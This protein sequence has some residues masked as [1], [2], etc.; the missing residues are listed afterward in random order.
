M[1]D[2][3]NEKERI[4]ERT[5]KSFIWFT[6]LPFALHFIRFANSIFLA[7]ILGPEAFG[8]IGIAI[9]L[10]FY[11]NSLA[12]FGFP[13]AIIQ[14]KNVEPEHYNT[15][16]SFS[17]L[18]SIV[19]FLLFSV[20]SGYIA[21]FFSEPRLEDVIAFISVVFLI[22]ALLI[23][24][25]TVIKR[26]INFKIL[27]IAEAIKVFSSMSMSITMALN[28]FGYWSIII[29]LVLSNFIAMVVVR[30][31]CDISPKLGWHKKH[32]YELLSFGKWDFLW[33]QLKL[34]SDNV[35][36]ILIGKLLGVT[37]LGLYDKAFG[38]AKMPN[39]QFSN[40]LTAVSFSTFSRVNGDNKELESYL[41]KT[42][43]INSFISVPMYIGL[44]L[45]AFDF[46]NTLLGKDWLFMASSLSILSVSFL[47]ASLAAPIISINIA[48]GDIKAQTFI[49]FW[50][51]ILLIGSLMWAVPYGIEKAAYAIAANNLFLLVASIYLLIKKSTIS[52]LSILNDIMPATISSILM[53]IAIV[54]GQTVLAD[55]ASIFR[56]LITV[57][58]GVIVYVA[59]VVL[60]PFKKWLF[61]R[62]NIFK[63]FHKMTGNMFK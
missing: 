10:L 26:N 24:P 12:N 44:S 6:I 38:I 4:K 46:T 47:L 17:L 34:I 33:G 22:N 58:L 62:N 7:R 14:R 19:L 50:G 41:S 32:F 42:N 63:V 52:N 56:L 40:R 5:K 35:D 59:C 23:V 45:T 43:V 28:G 13:K 55:S 30:M 60:I 48:M 20:T 9:V 39:E 29:A 2:Q 8:I 31:S 37:Q 15:F 11:S 18:I 57:V 53:L 25:Q 21:D 61:L 49:R 3:N 16:F 36:K 1:V 27:A 54:I 51:L